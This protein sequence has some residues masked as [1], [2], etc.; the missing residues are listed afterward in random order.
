[1]VNLPILIVLE[2]CHKNCNSSMNGLY[3]INLNYKN[4]ENHMFSNIP[5]KKN[6]EQ[7]MEL[8]PEYVINKP[9]VRYEYLDDTTDYNQ[10]KVHSI[11]LSNMKLFNKGVLFG[12]KSLEQK[13][14]ISN[15]DDIQEKKTSKLNNVIVLADEKNYSRDFLNCLGMTSGSPYL[16]TIH[17]PT[18]MFTFQIYGLEEP[19]NKI[20]NH[21]KNNAGLLII[22]KKQNYFKLQE[23]I[24]FYV[25]NISHIPILIVIEDYENNNKFENKFEHLIKSN[26]RYE[27][28]NK[29]TH[30]TLHLQKGNIFKHLNWFNSCVLAYKQQIKNTLELEELVKQF[31]ECNLSIDNWN[32]LNRLRLVYFSLKNFGYSSTISKTGWLCVY[33][34]KYKNTIGHS[35]LWNYTLTKFWVDEIHRLMSKNPQMNFAEIY[36]KYTHLSD[37]NLHKKYYTNEVLFSTQARNDWI[38]PNLQK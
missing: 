31:V 34:N 29:K 6:I 11:G 5:S 25:S 37:G 30:S 7:I 22:L 27:C 36:N 9:N 28:I 17:I 8:K 13:Q 38:E 23:K 4:N 21:V 26:V 16:C 3:D 20:F 18:K 10:Y 35:H 15:N 12:I 32:H 24:N 1:M 33:W 19:D 2:K 14:I